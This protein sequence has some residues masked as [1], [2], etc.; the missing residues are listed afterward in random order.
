MNLE[1]IRQYLSDLIEISGMSTSSVAGKAGVFRGNLQRWLKGMG[2]SL[3]PPGISKVLSALNIEAEHL[4]PAVV[5]HFEARD[6]APLLRVL[7]RESEGAFRM[8]YV[9]PEHA[10]PKDFLTMGIM[11]PL[12][13]FNP[14][15]RIVVW[16]PSALS[17][18]LPAPLSERGIA[19]MDVPADPYYSHPTIRVARETFSKIKDRELTPSE[20]DSVVSPGKGPSWGDLVVEAEKLGLTPREVLDLLKKRKGK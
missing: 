7:S 2:Q 9:A 4:S 19:W 5:H 3:G 6:A 20:F 14:R 16:Q 8:V 11:H 1:E 12:F 13:L 15:V 18:P 10:T 17:K